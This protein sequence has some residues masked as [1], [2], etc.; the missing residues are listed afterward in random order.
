M[1]LISCFFTLLYSAHLYWIPF[2]PFR[3]FRSPN[4][5]WKVFSKI[6]SWATVNTSILHCHKINVSPQY[7]Y[8]YLV[9]QLQENV[10]GL[11]RSFRTRN[12]KLYV[13]CIKKIVICFFMFN[14]PNYARWVSIH[15]RDI[16]MLE[17][18]QSLQLTCCSRVCKR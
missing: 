18:I 7:K 11:I 9:M 1:V 5:W 12:W 3:W 4:L 16:E 14:H 13:K 17:T 10:L 6:L 15:I 2:I 8:W